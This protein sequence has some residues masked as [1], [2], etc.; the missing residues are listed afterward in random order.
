MNM[1]GDDD[2]GGQCTSKFS[3]LSQY[4]GS[5]FYLPEKPVQE[6]IRIGQIMMNRE[7]ISLPGSELKEY[8]PH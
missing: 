7:R 6:I 2:S 1:L 5:R 4:R 3:I 8:L